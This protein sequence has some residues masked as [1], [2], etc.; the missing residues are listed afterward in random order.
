MS[1]KQNIHLLCNA[2]LDPVWLWEW[3]EGAAEAIST[4]RSAAEICE[5]NDT[6]IFNH[7]EVT[8]YKWVQ[9]YEPS[10]FKR[11][12]ALVKQGKWHIMGGWYLQPDCN[13]PSGESLVRQILLG[14]NYFKK[15]FGVEPNTAINFDPFGHSRGLVQIMAKSGYDS[16]LFGRPM[17]EL[18]ALPGD[19]FIWQG[20]DGSQLLA[21]R[22]TGWY[23]SP[24]GKAKETIEKRI[25]DDAD[26]SPLIVLW[27][28]GNHGGGPSK[29]DTKDVNELIKAD[30][31]NDIKHST[32]EHFFKDLAKQQ[33]TLQ[34]HKD[35]L[36]P[37]SVGCYSS[38][39]RIKQRHRMLENQFYTLEKMASA[40]MV[41]HL[42][43]YPYDEMHEALCDLMNSQFHDILPGSSIEAAEDA[44]LRQ[45]DHGLEKVA[46]LKA[47]AFFA[48]ASGQ[49]KANEGEIPIMVYNAQPVEITETI[50]CEFNLHDQK[51]KETYTQ[52]KVY[53]DGI[54][55]PVQ[56]EKERSNL[57]VEWRK[58]VVFTAKLKP[59]QMN[60]FDCK[61][62]I[63]KQKRA[64]DLQ[65]VDDKINFKT[66]DLQIVINTQTGLIDKYIAKGIPYLAPNAFLPIVI[67]DNED[68]WGMLVT[69]FREKIGAF[70]LMNKEKGT[71]F[72]GVNTGTIESVRI[73]E[74]GP[75]RSV[76]EA[77]MQYGDSFICQHY[78]L[79]KQG[80]QIEVETRV[81][82]HEK[83]KMLKLSVP[84]KDK[85]YQY[86]GQ[87]AY[88]T[89]VLPADG[90]ECVAQ[91]WVA[92]TSNK[93]DLAITC[94]NNGTYSSDFA[95]NELR[96]TLLRSPAYTAHP[97]IVKN[98]GFIDIP[99]DRYTARID[100]GLRVF[101]FWFNGGKV[102]EQLN[103]VT[104]D[105]LAKNETPF[106]LSF[107]PCGEGKVP[108]PLVTLTNNQIEV[109]T[110]KRTENNND[111][112]I[113][114]FEPTGKNQSTSMHLPFCNINKDIE[115]K[116]FEIKTFKLDLE[117][118]TFA[119]TDLLENPLKQTHDNENT[120][121]T[122][123]HHKSHPQNKIPREQAFAFKSNTVK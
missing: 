27:G 102:T 37:F 81:H 54:E 11:I 67:K 33:A 56:V 46:R 104:R 62:E 118:F 113:R 21:T 116:A 108:K 19:D 115:L 53:Q 69:S 25:A 44:A 6:F 80:T 75:V 41:N 1:K 114:L 12:Q 94:I 61:L 90:T 14:K 84:M 17:K 30:N 59:S 42:M 68:P 110:V 122:N 52:I 28:V 23:N 34:V 76:V 88:G 39:I 95:D 83:D 40:A 117:N 60:R 97:D 29:K 7:N 2:H 50:E 26:R 20:F 78:K 18:L 91:K 8:L 5:E 96:L 70:K 77:V 49:E 85:G 31:K 71:E 24:L 55:I 47:R 64:M 65:I 66:K 58:R 43:D 120:I 101:K 13:M 105:A 79:P 111:L 4:F 3:E 98:N 109:T 74:D 35:D 72:S 121:D 16:Y 86:L 99:T 112:I 48:M 73:I 89:Q 32:P 119:E 93:D 63:I 82:W 9:E 38:Q 22:F 123:R 100:Q 103:G 10:L 106:A 107:F 92:A 36:N 45:I 87:T 15:H 57:F 51:S